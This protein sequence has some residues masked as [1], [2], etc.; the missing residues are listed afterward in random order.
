VLFASVGLGEVRLVSFTLQRRLMA[1]ASAKEDKH[2]DESQAQLVPRGV[3]RRAVSPRYLALNL[4]PLMTAAFIKTV[5]SDLEGHMY[6]L[7]EI[8]T[9]LMEG[10]ELSGVLGAPTESSSKPKVL[11]LDESARRRAFEK[12]HEHQAATGPRS[13]L[14]GMRAYSRWAVH[15][16]PA[17]GTNLF[18][19]HQGF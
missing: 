7:Q 19:P 12:K 4:Q 6:T 3:E 16:E 10:A 8:L 18:D 5:F 9:G 2:G 17:R 13:R 1:E 15:Q 14:D 11:V